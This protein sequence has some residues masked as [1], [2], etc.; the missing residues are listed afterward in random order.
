MAYHNHILNWVSS[1]Y[2]TLVRNEMNLM[3]QHDKAD[4]FDIALSLRKY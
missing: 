1:Q 2:L 3:Q 4:L